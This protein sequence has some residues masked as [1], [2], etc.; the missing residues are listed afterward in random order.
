MIAS[1]VT[2]R[3]KLVESEA[4][5]KLHLE[6][7]KSIEVAELVDALGALSREFR[8]FCVTQN[9]TE[10]TAEARLLVS[11]VSPGSIDISFLPELAA[12]AGA[13]LP[14]MD[15]FEVVRK[16][17]EHIKWLLDGFLSPGGE[18]VSP[19]VSASQCDDAINIVKPIA[20]NGGTQSFTAIHGDV[21]LNI[22]QVSAPD[23]RRITNNAAKLKAELKGQDIEVAQRVPLVFSRLDSATAKVD[24]PSPDKA[25]IEE[26][27]PKPRP[28]LFT[29]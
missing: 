23:A 17:A 3:G 9:L 12:T 6:P 10:N 14:V 19:N 24:G 16:F 27:D 7:E 29:D 2:K 20:N 8:N 21:Y 13:L 28:V 25:V 15:Q 26:L 1:K 5:L 18:K 11:S 22:L 4:R